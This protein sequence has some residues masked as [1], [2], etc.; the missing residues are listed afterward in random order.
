MTNHWPQLSRPLAGAKKVVISLGLGVQSTVLCHMA[1]RGD[2]APMP[3]FAIFA[4][5]GGEMRRTYAALD[6]LAARLPFPIITVRRPGP[7]LAAVVLGVV[8][9][10]MPRKGAPMIPAYAL[11]GRERSMLPKQCSKFYKTR[12]VQRC[13]A[14]AL[15][16]AIGERGPSVPTVELW[17]GMTTDEMTRVATNERRWIHNRHPLVEL[18][19]NRAECI[20]WAELRQIPL[21]GKSSCKFCPFRDN[22]AW[23]AMHDNDPDDFAEACDFDDSIRDGWPGFTGQLFIH[24]GFVPLRQAVLTGPDPQT[25]FFKEC[26]A[27]GI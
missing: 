10:S 5:T 1:A 7:D 25:D 11:E 14:E 17:L 18:N 13:I 4:D 20:R 23:Q 15:G 21:P 6:Q 9:G 22:A 12:V 16:L 2:L 26:D 3:D 19:M 27:C 24:R 8:G